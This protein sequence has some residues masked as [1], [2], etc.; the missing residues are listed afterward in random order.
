MQSLQAFFDQHSRDIYTLARYLDRYLAE[1]T[2]PVFEQ[3]KA[4]LERLYPELGDGVYGVYGKYLFQPVHDQFK[5][6]GLRS[7]P[8][9]PFGG[10]S[11]SRE[12]GAEADRQRWCWSKITAA[13]GA[14]LG[15]IAL[16]F[17]HDHTA[18]RIPRPPRVV[19]LTE[20]S[21]GAV[22]AAL[23]RIEPE[24]GS[25]VEAKIEIAEYLAQLAQDTSTTA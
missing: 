7:T 5:Q 14:T 4:E 12:W 19:A 8:R 20:T 2:Q 13:D 6:V 18:I 24:F 10:F 9:L 22:I 11:A 3:H 21:K 16:G 15:T 23:S 1:N 17:Y 25:A